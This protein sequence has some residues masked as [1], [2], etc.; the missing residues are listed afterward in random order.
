[1][2]EI[3]ITNVDHVSSIHNRLDAFTDSYYYDKTRFEKRQTDTEQKIEAVRNASEEAL[4]LVDYKFQEIEQNY[5]IKDVIQLEEIKSIVCL[6]DITI[7]SK[8]KFSRFSKWLWKKLFGWI[9]IDV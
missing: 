4:K 1:M 5:V 2:A 8:K 6:G 9:I 7:K 3:R